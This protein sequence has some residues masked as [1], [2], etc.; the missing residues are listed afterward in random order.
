[1]LMLDNEDDNKQDWK[2]KRNERSDS[3]DQKPISVSETNVFIVLI[4]TARMVFA[5]EYKIVNPSNESP[6]NN[7]FENILQVIHVAFDGNGEL[8]L[9]LLQFLWWR[10]CIL[11]LE[12]L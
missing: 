9:F 12:L 3:I 11:F 5:K 2:E 7:S 6:N 10:I 4:Q 1:M 8:F